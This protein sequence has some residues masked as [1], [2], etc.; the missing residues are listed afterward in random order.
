VKHHGKKPNLKEP[1]VFVANHSSFIDYIVL[2]SYKF[3]H[4]TIAQKHGGIMGWFQNHVLNLNGSL[5]LERGCE[6]QRSQTKER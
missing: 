1:H 6:N 3:P 2:S 5:V 4:A